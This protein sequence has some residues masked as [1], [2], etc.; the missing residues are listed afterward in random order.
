MDIRELSTPWLFSEYIVYSELLK[1]GWTKELISTFLVPDL[2]AKNPHISTKIMRLYKK[3]IVFKIETEDNFKEALREECAKIDKKR[4]M[5]S[6]EQ[7]RQN[8][9]RRVE[10]KKLSSPVRFDKLDEIFNDK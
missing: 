2:I 1:R 4:Y 8:A 6:T 10:N 9:K 3:E 5:F 7:S